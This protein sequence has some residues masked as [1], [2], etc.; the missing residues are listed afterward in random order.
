MAKHSQKII[1]YRN[2]NLPPHFPI[3]LITGEEWRISD[4]PSG[5]L[6]FHNCLEIG[7]CESDS[8]TLGF[9]DI[10]IPFEAGDVTAIACDVPHTTYSSPGTA[11]KW[12]YL[13]VDPEEL[14]RPFFPLDMLPNAD[15]FRRILYGYRKIFSHK[16]YPTV[17]RLV[18][19][20]A[21]EMLARRLNYE[22][23]V[24][25]LFLTLMTELMRVQPASPADGYQSAI[26]IAPALRY[27]GEHY[28]DDCP[29]DTLAEICHIS[30]SHFRRIFREIMGVGPL[31]HLTQTRISK[32]CILLRMT[33]G[34]I[35]HISEQVGFRSLSS[36]NRH[37]VRIIGEPPTVWRKRMNDHQNVSILKYSGWLVPPR[38]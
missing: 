24:R 29:I 35:L 33:E 25:G 26:P 13:F 21:D 23:S 38:T 30:P 22:I 37:F 6:H 12:T 32:A 14:L 5:V 15:L 10:T 27:I 8:G 20:I 9:Q 28:R 31:E 34:S 17:Y 36:F 7:L 3:L 11:S 1:E 16:R 19:Q 4:I 18:W 2:Y